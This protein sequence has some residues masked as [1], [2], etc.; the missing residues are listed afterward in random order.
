M[1]KHHLSRKRSYNKYFYLYVFIHGEMKFFGRYFIDNNRMVHYP[2]GDTIPL[3]DFGDYVVS[4][5]KMSPE[6]AFHILM[7]D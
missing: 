5:D 2:D 6:T 1:S 7:R 3:E 4:T